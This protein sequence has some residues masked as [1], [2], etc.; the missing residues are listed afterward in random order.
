MARIMLTAFSSSGSSILTT[1]KRRVRAGSRSKYFLYSAHVVAAIVL[2]SPR[3]RAGFKRF[4]ASPW[5]SLPPAPIKV[6]ASSMN[7]MI[8]CG[9]AFT[10]AMTDFKRFSNSPFTLAPACN[11]PKSRVRT[12]TSF[13]GPGTSPEAI[14]KAKPSTTAV[15]PT[16]A[17]PV[18]IGLFWRRRIRIS[19]ICLISS[20]RPSTASILPCLA[21]SV[22]LTV[23]LSSDGVLLGADGLSDDEVSPISTLDDSAVVPTIEP[24]TTR[25]DSG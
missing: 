22:K 18:K 20:S 1:W 19:T 13:N 7:I 2:N 14:R 11:K 23:N 6:C 8:G 16:P 5:P 9:E 12:Q 15:L 17:S 21:A 3:A 25:K 4:A 24:T 10:S